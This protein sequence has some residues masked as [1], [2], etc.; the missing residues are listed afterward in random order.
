MDVRSRRKRKKKIDGLQIIRLAV[1]IIF[2]IF[3]PAL[4][5]N[6]FFEL[7][8]VW[9][10]LMD[11]SFDLVSLLPQIIEL[12]AIIPVTILL[13]RF[14]CG[15]LC[16]FG[17]FGDFIYKIA[18]KVFRINV[19]I[20]E[21]ADHALKFVKFG[22]LVFAVVFLWTL[23]IPGLSSASP[24]DVFGMIAT[25]GSAPAIGYVLANLTIGFIFFALIAVGSLF[26]QR[27]FCRYLCPLGAVFTI[28]SALK[29]TRIKKPAAGCGKCRI[30]TNACAMGIPLYKSDSIHSGECIECLQCVSACPRNNVT[31]SL[32]GNSVRP[33][34][35]GTMAAIAITGVYGSAGLA[36]AAPEN[37]AVSDSTI[38]SSDSAASAAD[39]LYVD[40]TYTGTG[41]GFRGA[42]TQVSV[43]ISGGVITDITPLSYGD[44]APYFERAFS[45]VSDDII[46]AQS[47]DVDAVSGAT[48]SSAGIMEAV[49]D[50]LSQAGLSVQTEEESAET[51]EASEETSSLPADSAAPSTES[52]SESGNR[53]RSG[54]SSLSD[55]ATT[56]NETSS[57][58]D[59]ASSSSS[60]ASY[61]DGTYTGTGTGFHG[62]TTQVSVTVS[63]GVITDITP[64]S[65]GDDAPYFERAFSSVSEDIISTQSADVDAV[66]G[67]T[68]S[69]DGIMEAVQD[70]LSQAAL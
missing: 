34:V 23:D 2:F 1:Q 12:I 45:S 70:A 65:Y 26:I 43:T 59:A 68:Y 30:C 19:K 33:L 46:S 56:D 41:T 64:L 61:T 62:A 5:I 22:I 51:A 63:G 27:F 54:Q 4:Y 66:S 55:S 6:A 11:G 37:A 8:L 58:S 9:G 50:A 52:V 57:A 48:Y 13:G 67:A 35:A 28:L 29:L 3:L 24:W 10:S 21:K 69:S 39:S 15:W 36:L 31:Y 44:D 47:A 49:Q 32:A 53:S 42:T 17:A 38:S 25:V 14:F 18:K 16:A 7:K 20:N 40:G 60:D